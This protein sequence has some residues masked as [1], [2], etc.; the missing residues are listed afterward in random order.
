MKKLYTSENYI[1][2]LLTCTLLFSLYLLVTITDS[3]KYVLEFIGMIVVF[4]LLGY[5][6]NTL[7]NKYIK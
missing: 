6:I 7:A 4:P 2:G 5:V 1:T 3:W